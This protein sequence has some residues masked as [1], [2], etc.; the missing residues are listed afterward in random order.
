MT[1]HA[2]LFEFNLIQ[3]RF[4]SLIQNSKFNSR[5][6]NGISIQSKG[7]GM[8]IVIKNIESMLMSGVLK[9]K[10]L[11]RHKF[12]NAYLSIPCYLRID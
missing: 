11:K 1:L 8:Q 2:N 4:L 9:K 10:T 12:E 3:F 5:T 7:N 6:L